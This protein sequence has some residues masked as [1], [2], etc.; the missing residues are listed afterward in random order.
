MLLDTHYYTM[1]TMSLNVLCTFCPGK[2]NIQG[3]PHFTKLK[4]YNPNLLDRCDLI[5]GLQIDHTRWLD[6]QHLLYPVVKD[7]IV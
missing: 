1:A 6:Q 5:S 3:H 4:G 2:L 7:F